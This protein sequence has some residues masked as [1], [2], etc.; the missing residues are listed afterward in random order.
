MLSKNILKIY[1]F[2]VFAYKFVVFTD[3]GQPKWLANLSGFLESLKIA[4]WPT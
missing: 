1:K 2:V 3:F 4:E